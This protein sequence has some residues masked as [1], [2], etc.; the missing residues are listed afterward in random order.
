MS[1]INKNLMAE[2]ISAFEGKKKQVDIAQIKE[3]LKITLSIL[4]RHW[5]SGNEEG[6]IKL[7]KT[8]TETIK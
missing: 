6:V 2:E 5:N 4:G 1:K 3:V 8:A 7:I